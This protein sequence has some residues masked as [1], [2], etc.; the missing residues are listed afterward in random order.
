MTGASVNYKSA[1]GDLW[2][3]RVSAGVADIASDP[4]WRVKQG[5]SSPASAIVFRCGTGSIRRTTD[6]FAAVDVDVTPGTNPPNDAGDSPAPTVGNVTFRQMEGSYLVQDTFVFMATWQNASSVWRTWLLYTDD[7]GSTWTWQSVSSGVGD[8]VDSYDTAQVLKDDGEW[9]AMLDGVAMTPSKGIM[10]YV[11]WDGDLE[12]RVRVYNIQTGGVFVQGD[13]YQVTHWPDATVKEFNYVKLI[14]WDNTKFLAVYEVY[15]ETWSPI[16]ER[17]QVWARSGEL[18]GDIVNWGEA[19]LVSINATG[20]AT[21]ITVKQIS[22]TKA[23]VCYGAF[24]WYVSLRIITRLGNTIISVGD[25]RQLDGYR[26]DGYNDPAIHVL[27]D[28]FLAVS[29]VRRVLSW[30]PGYPVGEE[31]LY[32]VLAVIGTSTAVFQPTT[33]KEVSSDLVYEVRG[34]ALDSTSYLIAFR[35]QGSSRPIRGVVATVT[36]FGISLGTEQGIDNDTWGWELLRLTDDSFLLEYQSRDNWPDALLHKVGTISA[37]T[38]SMGTETDT[39]DDHG[40]PSALALHGATKV[41]T[42]YQNIAVHPSGDYNIKAQVIHIEEDGLA[43]RGLGLSLSKGAV[44]KAW[45]TLNDDNNLVLVAYDL[46]DLTLIAAERLGAASWSETEDRSYLCY[47][48]VPFGYDD[49]VYVFG[50]MNAPRGFGNPTHIIRT[51]DGGSVFEAIEDG[52]LFDHCGALVVDI[53]GT[54]FAI[55]NQAA[56]ATLYRDNIDN[57]LVLKVTLPFD[58]AVAPHGMLVDFVS[59]DVYPA[60]WGADPVMVV[61]IAPPHLTYTDLTFNHDNTDG[62]ESIIGL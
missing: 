35:E 15:N 59:Q 28:T 21:G 29:F 44:E 32:T 48:F 7:N 25:E 37:G 47:P 45:L 42:L 50:R 1:S 52:W 14:R 60:S 49:A 40:E 26:L 61:K 27:S 38:I 24:G 18:T 54:M 10:G 46:P 13:E 8:E 20:R 57:N 33:V 36:G 62:I 12:G 23:A 9:P 51:L 56:K 55:R 19:K 58:A 3:Q 43:N 2:V 41:V 11:M 6:A 16:G 53:S 4:F 22:E 30:E 39:L 17:F 34:H 31:Y 5:T